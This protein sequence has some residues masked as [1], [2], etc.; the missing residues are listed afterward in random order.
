MLDEFIRIG[1]VWVLRLVFLV[2]WYIFMDYYNCFLVKFVFIFVDLDII[3]GYFYII[4]SVFNII[5]GVFYMYCSIFKLII[6]GVFY[7][8]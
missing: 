1:V 3:F 6:F 5:L 2:E 4:F 8:F 7:S